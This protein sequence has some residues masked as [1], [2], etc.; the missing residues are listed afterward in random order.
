MSEK[1]IVV[2]GAGD[3]SF[4][5]GFLRKIGKPDVKPY[6]PKEIGGTGNGVSNVIKYI[7]LLIS[8]IEAG[9]VSEAAI[10]VDA[11]YP[12][13]NG[14]FAARRGEI[15]NKLALTGYVI[16]PWTSNENPAGEIFHPKS[17]INNL[18][19]IGLFIM[20]NHH[21]D[22]MLEDLL[23]SM[24]TSEQ[25]S[26]L[27]QHAVASTDTLPNKL[28]NTHLHLSKAE[29][30]SFLA[31]QKEPSAP[32]G[33]AIKED[34]FSVDAPGCARLKDW[35]DLVFSPPNNNTNIT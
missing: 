5:Q 17:E 16:P 6:P 23:K 27:L 3:K 33:K 9:E 24:I 26:R 7:D 32:I 4:I 21:A 31:W 20:P 34:I 18:I 1:W 10:L 14:G 11:D 8:K 29:I 19:P 15:T 22:G 13:S 25:Q 30:G 12:E 35:L 28:F 2:E